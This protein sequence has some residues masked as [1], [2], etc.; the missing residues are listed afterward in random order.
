MKKR[1]LTCGSSASRR[2]Y[3]FGDQYLSILIPCRGTPIEHLDDFVVERTLGQKVFIY[4][5]DKGVKDVLNV[6]AN[7]SVGGVC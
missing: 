6:S 4:L 1:N 5:I 7:S 2:E 3:I